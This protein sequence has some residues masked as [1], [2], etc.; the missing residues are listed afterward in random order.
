MIK[1]SMMKKKREMK[2]TRR[3]LCVCMCTAIISG[4]YQYMSWSWASRVCIQLILTH[5]IGEDPRWNPIMPTHWINYM[6]KQ[7]S[8]GNQ[9]PPNAE[10]NCC[11]L[12]SFVVCC[13]YAAVKAARAATAPDVDR[14]EVNSFALHSALVSYYNV[15][16]KLKIQF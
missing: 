9:D 10:M 2:M 3:N 16:R 12:E 11:C 8:D 1:L 4:V 13:V 5:R 7:H 15:N 6:A 14:Y